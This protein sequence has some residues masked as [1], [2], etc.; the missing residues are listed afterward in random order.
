MKILLFNEITTD[1][2]HYDY[3]NKWVDEETGVVY[4]SY[5]KE[6]D[7]EAI[8]RYV[9]F[10]K[11]VLKSWHNRLLICYENSKGKKTSQIKQIFRDE[12]D[13]EATDYPSY[14]G[15]FILEKIQN[16][17]DDRGL[18]YFIHTNGRNMYK[19]VESK[20]PFLNIK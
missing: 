8:K 15:G 11:K 19:S 9:K 12:F 16:W 20:I 2:N 17:S 4:Y 14:N 7:T 6:N 5:F 18:L 10:E 1:F 13:N 3:P